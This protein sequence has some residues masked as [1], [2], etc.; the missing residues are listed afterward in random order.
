MPGRT[1]R[2]WVV[3][4]VL[5]LALVIGVV[6]A[7]L[8]GGT[9]GPVGPAPTHAGE[10]IVN[11]P[12]AVWGLIFLAPLLVGWAAILLRRLLGGSMSY[13]S[14]TL[15]IAGV[16]FAVAI[17]F[18]YVLSVVGSG[19]GGWLGVSGSSST[20]SNSTNSSSSGGG[21]NSSGTG[22]PVYGPALK[23]PAWAIFL[24]VGVLCALVAAVAVPGVL[25][26]LVDRRPRG[27]GAAGS[28]AAAR[29]ELAKA[30]AEASA[31]LDAGADPRTTI[32]RLYQRLLVELVPKVGDIDRLTAEE[33][34]TLPLAQLNVRPD[35]AEALTRLFEEAR[36]STHPLGPS[37]ADRCREALRAIEADLARAR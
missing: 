30:L 24:F 16:L 25:A 18:V 37:S 12:P 6:S 3:Y 10:L 9:P 4:V 34:R 11:L 8:V 15:L 21:S 14:R 35:A 32:V 28:S 13:G 7:V 1:S 22:T 20:S 19:G 36:Y 23:L 27:F 29:E 31:A 17:L 5:L 33:I 26:S 2:T